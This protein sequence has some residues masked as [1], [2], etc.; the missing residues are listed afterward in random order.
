METDVIDGF[1]FNSFVSIEQLNSFVDK[2]LSSNLNG[3]TDDSLNGFEQQELIL[4]LICPST[5]KNQVN[6]KSQ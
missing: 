2:E 4:P 6:D 5:V 3:L 1:T